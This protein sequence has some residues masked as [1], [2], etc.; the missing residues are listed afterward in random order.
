MHVFDAT[1]SFFLKLAFGHR[2]FSSVEIDL[3]KAVLFTPVICSWHLQEIWPLV[4]G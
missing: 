3:C 2:L 1:K 4:K